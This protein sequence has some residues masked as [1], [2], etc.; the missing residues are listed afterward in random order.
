LLAPAIETNASSEL[1]IR[2]RGTDQ[3]ELQCC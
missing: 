2:E 1:S 3:E